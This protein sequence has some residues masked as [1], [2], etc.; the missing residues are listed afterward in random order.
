MIYQYHLLYTLVV[1]H[2]Q[3]LGVSNIILFSNI[4]YLDV[5]IY[6]GMIERWGKDFHNN[7]VIGGSSAG[8]VMALGDIAIYS[9]NNN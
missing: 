8:I 1:V 2:L 5:G 4:T 9:S 6:K 7:T 3:V